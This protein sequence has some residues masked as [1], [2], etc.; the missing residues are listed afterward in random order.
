VRSSSQRCAALRSVAY[1]LCFFLNVAFYFGFALRGASFVESA[2]LRQ[3]I[4]I[5]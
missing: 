1:K 5:V 3:S 4:Q 2:F